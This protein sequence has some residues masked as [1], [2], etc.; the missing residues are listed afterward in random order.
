[1]CMMDFGMGP[2]GIPIP[3]EVHQEYSDEL[4]G[5]WEIFDNWWHSVREMGNVSKK[6][7]PEEV[8]VAY[9]KI[10]ETEI[11]GTGHPGSESCY[12]NGV[13]MMLLD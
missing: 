8:L 2:H 3:E 11:P 5:Y 1:M 6:D 13:N 9:N 7:M 10:M 4:K 12:M